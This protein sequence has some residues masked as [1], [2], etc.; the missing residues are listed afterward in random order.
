MGV[1]NGLGFC[2]IDGM[3]MQGVFDGRARSISN[4][5]LI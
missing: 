3:T 2:E 1:G 5:H 4:I